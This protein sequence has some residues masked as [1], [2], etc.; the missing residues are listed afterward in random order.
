M[1]QKGTIFNGASPPPVAAFWLLLSSSYLPDMQ[2]QNCS[3]RA[4]QATAKCS[5]NGNG[6][7]KGE[8]RTLDNQFQGSRNGNSNGEDRTLNNQCPRLK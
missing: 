4:G 7:S 1:G 2:A 8:D 6:K 3:L 5:R